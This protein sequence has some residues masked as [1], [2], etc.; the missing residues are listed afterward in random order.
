MTLSSDQWSAGASYEQFMGRWSRSLAPVFVD[1]LGVSPGLHWLE[2]GCGTGALTA[3]IASRTAPASIVACDPAEPFIAFARS[4]NH[5]ERITFAIA[6]ADDFPWRLGGYNSITSLLALNFVPNQEAAIRRM[7][8]ALASGGVIS[9]CVWDYAEG[10]Q[11][12]RHFWDA[13]IAVRPAAAEVDE[14][15]RFPMCRPETLRALF[16]VV[17]LDAVSCQ[18]IEIDTDFSNFEDYWTPFLGGTGP[19]P[20]FVASL[21]AV[22]R[23]RLREELQRALTDAEDDPIRLRAR[24]WAIRGHKA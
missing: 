4:Q 13:A 3:A 16:S 1:W 2:I 14:A 11:F 18:A 20:A 6:R 8:E 17:E 15:Q 5:D 23:K 24:A 12:L 22:E 10:M 21:S 19:A 7:H 9:A